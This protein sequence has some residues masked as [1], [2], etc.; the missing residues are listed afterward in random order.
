MLYWRSDNELRWIRP[1]Q[2]TFES[3][4]T[5][6]FFIVCSI[7]GRLFFLTVCLHVLA[8]SF[9][10]VK[11][12]EI[13]Q[14]TTNLLFFLFQFKFSSFPSFLRSSKTWGEAIWSSKHIF[15]WDGLSCIEW[16]YRFRLAQIT[17]FFVKFGRSHKLTDG[18]RATEERTR[19]VKLLG[20]HSSS[21]S[22]SKHKRSTTAHMFSSAQSKT[23]LHVIVF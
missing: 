10:L 8:M 1:S 3:F 14:R 11:K 20:S 15:L 9:C 16:E 4:V 18:K 2:S 13:A 12:R 19:W 7:Y 6:S 23:I 22:T 5:R 17:V 21:S